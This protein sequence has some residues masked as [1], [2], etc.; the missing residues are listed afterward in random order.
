MHLPGF[1]KMFA[2]C[3]KFILIAPTCRIAFSTCKT[4][5][6]LLLDTIREIKY[7]EIET[8]SPMPVHRDLGSQC[9]RWYRESLGTLMDL[10]FDCKPFD[11]HVLSSLLDTTLHP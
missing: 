2:V 7:L 10:Q 3:S 5:N 4:R 6:V 1:D 8:T 9:A 11:Q